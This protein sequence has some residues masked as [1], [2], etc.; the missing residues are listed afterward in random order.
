MKNYR[1]YF[2]DIDY[3]TRLRSGLDKL[4]SEL[5]YVFLED[6]LDIE[7]NVIRDN[8][9]ESIILNNCI[10]INKCSENDKWILKSP[11]NEYYKVSDLSAKIF[12]YGIR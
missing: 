2:K 5:G 12:K 6:E 11:L 8:E 7:L 3:D 4:I 9:I 1:D 10:M